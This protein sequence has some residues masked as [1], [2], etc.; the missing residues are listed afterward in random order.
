VALAAPG[1]G[2]APG[3]PAAAVCSSARATSTRRRVAGVMRA[4]RRR[5]REAVLAETPARAPT[6]RSV[7]AWLDRI[8]LRQCSDSHCT[9]A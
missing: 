7:G 8:V 5:A 3:P 9:H 2:A 6:S 1:C 4:S